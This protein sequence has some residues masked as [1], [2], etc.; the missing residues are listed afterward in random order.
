[1]G[2]R[3]LMTHQV[4]PYGAVGEAVVER[5]GVGPGVAEDHIHPLLR[6]GFQNNVRTDRIHEVA[7]FEK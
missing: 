1:M 5:Q 6:Q 7:P 3:L 2:R 4:V